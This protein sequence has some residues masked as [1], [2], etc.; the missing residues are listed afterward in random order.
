MYNK[1]LLTGLNN[2]KTRGK[3][4]ENTLFLYKHYSI[5][6]AYPGR[7]S[8]KIKGANLNINK[9]YQ[10]TAKNYIMSKMSINCV[11]EM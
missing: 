6:D 8:Q 4:R 5:L 7:I 2:I 1:E 9:I 10:Q 3:E 11:K